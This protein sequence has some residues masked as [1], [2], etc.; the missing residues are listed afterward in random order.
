MKY[1]NLLV[2][3]SAFFVPYVIKAQAN[4]PAPLNI[5]VKLTEGTNMAAALSPDKK[6]LAID[7]QGTIWVMSSHGGKAIPITDDL[8]D[9]HEPTW[10]PDGKRIAFHSY[11][12][13]TYHI[14]T[15]KKD[16]TDLQQIT[17]G[18]FD[19]REPSWSRDNKS[20][21]FSS[22]RLGNYDLWTVDIASRKT[23]A[24]TTSK[25]DEYNPSVSPDGKKIAF[26]SEGKERGIYILENGKA[27]LAAASTLTLNAPSWNE[28]GEHIVYIS[29]ERGISK[30]NL[31]HT[32]SKSSVVLSANE[33][34]FPFKAS[35]ISNNSFLYTGN[36]KIQKRYLG[37]ERISHIPF[38]ASIIL[39]R[40][41]YKRKQYHFDDK[42]EQKA[43][44]IVGPVA[45]PDGRS[46]AFAAIGNI[47]IQEIGGKLTQVT[48]DSYVDLDPDWS[49][50]GKTLAYVSDRGGKMEIWLHDIQSGKSRILKTEISGS[51]SQPCWSPDGKTIAFYSKDMNEW[52]R[53]VLYLIHPQT[54]ELRKLHHAIFVPAKPS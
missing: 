29:Y 43:L 49:P 45:S 5:E 42:N 35:W 2:F 16:G 11:R 54:S 50:D 25:E 20:I 19:D 7:L 27:S 24:I 36:G 38:E 12:T 47:Y 9:C 39:E 52:G 3:L 18:I 8:G 17:D 21:I 53:G 28:N 46:V 6:T 13:G 4:K 33:D 26:V 31:I 14:W 48:N 41:G 34:I 32:K 15:V 51:A 1:I 37:D 23:R 10:S 30:L 40:E 44:G 22:D